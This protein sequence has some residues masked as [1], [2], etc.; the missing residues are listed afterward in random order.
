MSDPESREP[1][2]QTLPDSGL[3]ARQIEFPVVM[4]LKNDPDFSHDKTGQKRSLIVSRANSGSKKGYWSVYPGPI[5][6][7]DFWMDQTMISFID[8]FSSK[9]ILLSTRSFSCSRQAQKEDDCL[10]P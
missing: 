10:I 8:I 6:S 7:M 5:F 1:S 4:A 9:E 3:F 2:F